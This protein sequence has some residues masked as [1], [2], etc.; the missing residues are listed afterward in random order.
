MAR[1]LSVMAALRAL[2]GFLGPFLLI[3]ALTLLDV[4]VVGDS[5]GALL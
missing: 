2:G 5:L 4:P 1:A 3:L